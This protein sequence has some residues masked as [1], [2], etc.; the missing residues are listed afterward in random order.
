MLFN[1]LS[2]S[3]AQIGV[4]SYSYVIQSISRTLSAIFCKPKPEMEPVPATGRFG[5]VRYRFGFQAGRSAV[6]PVRPVP[7]MAHTQRQLANVRSEVVVRN[8]VMI[9]KD[10]KRNM[11]FCKRFRL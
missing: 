1:N 5:P 9:V 6:R 11:Y 8:I 7:S 10:S 4:F 3:L 2:F